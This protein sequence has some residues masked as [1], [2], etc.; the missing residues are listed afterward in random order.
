MQSCTTI[1]WPARHTFI[2]ADSQ[3]EAV[4][5]WGGSGGQRAS[6]AALTAQKAMVRAP[7]WAV[8]HAG[9]GLPVQVVSTHSIA[10]P[11]S[12]QA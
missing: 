4:P 9:A 3:K 8:T 11:L 5:P 6:G 7:L 1:T 2:F 10:N 12:M